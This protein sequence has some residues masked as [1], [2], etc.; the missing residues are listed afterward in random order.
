MTADYEEFLTP[1]EIEE[2]DDAAPAAG[3]IDPTFK[4]QHSEG[5]RWCF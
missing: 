2:Q 4:D 3:N 5:F 1:E